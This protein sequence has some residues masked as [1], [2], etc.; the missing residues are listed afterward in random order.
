M[1]RAGLLSCPQRVYKELGPTVESVAWAC[2]NAMATSAGVPAAMQAVVKLCREELQPVRD[3]SLPPPTSAGTGAGV[4]AGT[5]AGVG[6]AA[7]SSATPVVPGAPT[8]QLPA[9]KP[10]PPPGSPK[11]GPAAPVVGVCP[12]AVDYD[13]DAKLKLS[14]WPEGRLRRREAAIG[15]GGSSSNW[16]T[17]FRPVVV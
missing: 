9:S 8:A 5:G 11:Q 7:G 16:V 13:D 17:G 1:I 10:A 3:R 14:L 6:A 2:Y 12:P 15:R 4:G